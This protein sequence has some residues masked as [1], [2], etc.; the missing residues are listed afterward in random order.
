MLCVCALCLT[1]CL[2]TFFIAL[3]SAGE[4]LPEAFRTSLEADRHEADL[5]LVMG[6]SLKVRPVAGML[7][8]FPRSTPMLLINRETVGAPDTEFD[9]EMLGLADDICAYITQQ[10][11]WKLPEVDSKLDMFR[12]E[13]P[14]PA[15][16]VKGVEVAA[17]AASAASNLEPPSLPVSSSP[18][19][20]PRPSTPEFVLPNRYIFAG[21]SVSVAQSGSSAASSGASEGEEEED[22]LASV[23]LSPEIASS[24]LP[25]ARSTA[26]VP[27]DLQLP[28]SSAAALSSLDLVDV[29]PAPQQNGYS[30][31]Q[32]PISA[33]TTPSGLLPLSTLSAPSTPRKG[34]TTL[35]PQLS[36]PLHTAMGSPRTRLARPPPLQLASSDRHAA[37][38]LPLSSAAAASA[39]DAAAAGHS[40]VA[41]AAAAHPHPHGHGP[42]HSGVAELNLTCTPTKG[43]CARACSHGG[44]G[45]SGAATNS[46]PHFRALPFQAAISTV[47]HHPHPHHHPALHGSSPSTTHAAIPAAPVSLCNG[48]SANGSANGVS[49]AAASPSASASVTLIGCKRKEPA[50]GMASVA[51]AQQTTQQQVQTPAASP[52]APASETIHAPLVKR[53]R[54]EPEQKQEA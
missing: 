22:A 3:S 16:G 19:P 46:S 2:C 21:A 14:S 20:L 38:A 1:L 28:Q 23:P 48:A 35:P 54:T 49:S 15:D 36:S 7:S 50:A 51:Q 31:A 42:A 13:S 8:F 24:P 30:V 5:I 34:A 52:P 4:S 27:A 33:V 25:A 41:S 53:R 45:A 43:I 39:S 37:A 44:G 26:A 10:L 12:E 29:L 18:P 17:G 9:V 40:S 6:S 32:P 47:A 11:G